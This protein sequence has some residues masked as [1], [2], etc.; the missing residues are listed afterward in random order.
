MAIFKIQKRP[1]RSVQV[2]IIFFVFFH[3]KFIERINNV[4]EKKNPI[5]A[6]DGLFTSAYSEICFFY[7]VVTTLATQHGE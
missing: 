5:Y 4:K 1:N 7:L 2:T 3:Q 6:G